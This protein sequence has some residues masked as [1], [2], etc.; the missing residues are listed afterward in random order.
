MP[1]IQHQYEETYYMAAGGW[2]FERA[3][4]QGSSY[5]QLPRFLC[6]VVGNAN[7]HHV[8]HFSAKIPNYNLRRAHDEQPLFAA[9]P[10]VTIRSSLSC[11][12]LKLWDEQRDCL[13]RFPR[14]A[15]VEQEHRPAERERVAVAESLLLHQPAVDPR[16]VS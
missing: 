12:R 11:L 13:V 7:F 5:L 15:R 9:T 6:W 4:L 2:D 1:Y 3:A 10:V 8:H 16:S 14:S